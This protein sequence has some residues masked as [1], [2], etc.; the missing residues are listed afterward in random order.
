[1]A[2]EKLTVQTDLI[3]QSIDFTNQF[4][5]GLTTLLQVLGVTRR[6]AL[7]VGNQIKI[8]ETD[9]DLADGKV[10]EGEIIPLS[11]VTKKLAKTITLDYNKHRKEVTAE[12]IQGSGFQAAV[13]D[14]DT[15][16]LRANQKDVKKSL[17]DFVTTAEGATQVTAESFQK[18]IALALGNLAVKF[19]DDDVQSVLFVNPLDFYQYLGDKEIQTQ[20]SFGL[21]YLQGFLGF[22][23]I[24]LTAGVPQGKLAVTAANNLVMAYAPVSGQ[25]NQAFSFT[26]DETGLIG[27]AHSPKNENLSYDTVTLSAV[28]LFPEMVDGIIQ[29]D[30]SKKA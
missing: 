4:K 23:T 17:L 15:E 9:T 5:A 30:F 20:N 6:Q 13:I 26:T 25:L 11:K 3:A 8:Y 18:A 22:N 14:T 19:E 27:V 29:A 16:L 7:S 2:D 10:A 12:A 21:Q 28:K 24:I 1:M